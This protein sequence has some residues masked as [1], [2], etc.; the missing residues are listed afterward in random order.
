MGM[1]GIGRMGAV[2]VVALTLL[3]ACGSDDETASGPESG[4]ST[5]PPSTSTTTAPGATS[6]TVDRRDPSTVETTPIDIASKGDVLPDGTVFGYIT[7]LIAGHN[8]IVGK[9]DLAELLTGEAAQKAAAAAGTE[10]Y[11]DYFIR[12]TS[13]KLRDIK[14]DP[15]VVVEDVAYGDDCCELRSVDIAQW[16]ADRE[17][18]HE[19]ST[20]VFIT[21]SGGEVTAIREQFFP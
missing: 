19:T 15:T 9:F 8:E 11:D 4:S 12:N 5:A 6:T 13:K 3:T 21:I 10:A 7:E 14:V 1:R 17:A 20:S 16:V 18:N 2:A